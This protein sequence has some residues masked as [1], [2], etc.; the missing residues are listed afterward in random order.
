M[1]FLDGATRETVLTAKILFGGAVSLVVGTVVAYNWVFGT[2]YTNANADELKSE[3]VKKEDI[4]KLEDVLKGLDRAVKYQRLNL[5]NNTIH[6][7]KNDIKVSPDQDEKEFLK[8]SVKILQAEKHEI[9]KDL[10]YSK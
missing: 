5:I 3:M 7:K 8:D 1:G 2:F 9:E 6:D 10:G 4:R